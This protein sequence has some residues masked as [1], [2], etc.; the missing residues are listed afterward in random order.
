MS[1][2]KERLRSAYRG[3]V[4]RLSVHPS[5]YPLQFERHDDGSRHFEKDGEGW[6]VVT[7]ERGS[8]FDHASLPSDEEALFLQTSDLTFS[9]ACDYE[10][11]HRIE[12]DDCRRMIAAHQIELMGKI[13][14]DWENRTKRKWAETFRNN[15]LINTNLREPN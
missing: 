5:A 14:S 8:E 1:P 12:S 9:M 2:A 3:I 7:T 4:E 6:K 11:A 10:L 13:S 15:P